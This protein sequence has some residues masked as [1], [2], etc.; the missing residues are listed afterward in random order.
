M[1]HLVERS[2]RD[3]TFPAKLCV[4]RYM[5][6]QWKRTNNRTTTSFA[7]SSCFGPSL[8]STFPV[9]IHLPLLFGL[10]TRAA[11]GKQEQ[12]ARVD[13]VSSG[14]SAE[15][16][17]SEGPPASSALGKRCPG[18][19]EARGRHRVASGLA[20][21]RSPCRHSCGSGTPAAGWDSV[22]TAAPS[23]AVRDCNSP[24]VSGR[25]WIAAAALSVSGL[26]STDPSCPVQLGTQLH[27]GFPVKLG[28][29]EAHSL[30][31]AAAGRDARAFA[32]A[33][34]AL[35]SCG[36]ALNLTAFSWKTVGMEM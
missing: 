35:C 14:R 29:S 1:R 12:C 26:G 30:S 25:D 9:F 8:I 21:V 31:A 15:S 13:W 11:D 16:A 6:E 3:V 33:L 2:L 18:L 22:P 32:S 10:S 20:G 27:G 36:L 4:T 19:Q 7:Y 5:N 17:D 24:A 34:A 23:A 28:A